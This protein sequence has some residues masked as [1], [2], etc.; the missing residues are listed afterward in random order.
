[1]S[2]YVEMMASFAI[3]R[4]FLSYQVTY[5]P[6]IALGIWRFGAEIRV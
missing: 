6:G 2:K 5:C 3:V 1:M 4:H